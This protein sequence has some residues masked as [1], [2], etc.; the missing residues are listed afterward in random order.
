MIRLASKWPFGSLW[1]NF[2]DA[3]CVDGVS[4]AGA[5]SHTKRTC[6]ESPAHR[7]HQFTFV[8]SF[9]GLY[10]DFAIQISL[11][12]SMFRMIK[13]RRKGLKKGR[14]QNQVELIAIIYI[15]SEIKDTFSVSRSITGKSKI[16]EMPSLSVK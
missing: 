1:G 15:T 10:G 12:L 14:C 2:I 3:G 11:I 7:D 16:R 9:F 6:P 13:W 8:Q 5:M 4:V